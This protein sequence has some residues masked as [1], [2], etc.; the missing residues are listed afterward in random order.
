[1]QYQNLS[2]RSRL[3]LAFGGLAALTLL[4]AGFAIQSVSETNERFVNYVGGI[5]A[6]AQVSAEVRTAVDRR[7]IAARNLVLVTRPEDL[8]A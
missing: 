1:M 3:T 2:F 7:A 4:V 6:R 5:N 8:A